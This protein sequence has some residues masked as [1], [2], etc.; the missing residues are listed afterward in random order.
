[1]ENEEG[2]MV[3][4][5]TRRHAFSVPRTMLARP[6]PVASRTEEGEEGS[7]LAIYD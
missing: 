5:R 2:R 1:M 3:R 7:S 4:V 6:G